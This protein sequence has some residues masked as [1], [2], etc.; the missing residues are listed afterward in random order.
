MIVH[1]SFF[2]SG[3]RMYF[4]NKDEIYLLDGKIVYQYYMSN[5]RKSIPYQTFKEKGHFIKQGY[6]NRVD[7]LSIIDEVYIKN[8]R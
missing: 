2:Q 5:E 4:K 8:N 6:V 3:I 1:H 7:Y